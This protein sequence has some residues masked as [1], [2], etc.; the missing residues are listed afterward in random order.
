MTEQ[1]GTFALGAKAATTASAV[2]LGKLFTIIVAGL[3][4]ILVARLLGPASYGIYAATIAITGLFLSSGDFGIGTTFTKFIAEYSGTHNNR[5]M[6]ELLVN[7]YLLLIITGMLCSLVVFALSGVVA[8]YVLHNSAYA[9]VVELAAFTI[10]TYV[11]Y[12][13]SYSVLVG[14][15][16]SINISLGVVTQVVV[17]AIFSLALA[18][19]GYGALAPIIGLL[20][21]S[22]AGTVFTMCAILRRVSVAGARISMKA[23]KRILHFA[24]PLAV[25]GLIAS[26]MG[27]ITV[28]TLGI[29]ATTSMVGYFGIV[30][31]TS[32][33][34]GVI[35]DS[36]AIAILPMFVARLA[37]YRN[38]PRKSNSFYSY[39][40][41]VAFLFITPIMLYIILLSRPF[42]VTVF[43]GSYAPASPYVAIMS[44]GVLI[45]ITGTYASNLLT[46]ANKVMFIVKCNALI[47]LVQLASLALVPAFKDIGAIVQ[48]FIITPIATTLIFFY[49]T[50]KVLNARLDLGKILRVVLASL[51]SAAFVLPLIYFEGNYI[52]LLVS[53]VIEQLLL[54]PPILAIT[55]AATHKDL[56]ILKRVSGSIPVVSFI[57]GALVD[58]SEVFCPVS[59]T[60]T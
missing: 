1:E 43:G 29:F 10:I 57:M 33:L 52:L 44:I 21:G 46:S 50:R 4:F 25:S 15:G 12:N 41:Y 56:Q 8:T 34:V 16:S 42:T 27:N 19:S 14:F 20:L 3:T 9:Y 38:K 40:V 45:G 32:I 36:I 59:R 58:Y 47:A 48:M 22:I 31:R 49:A 51:I 30:Q 7:G 5:K 13:A 39:A 37:Q 17:Q 60:E 53:A 24:V 18:F 11:L 28:V 54:Y 23:T 55:S 26:I 6:A 35:S 2:L